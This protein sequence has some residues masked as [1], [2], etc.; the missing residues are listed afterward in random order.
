VSTAGWN[1]ACPDWELRIVAGESIIPALP[2]DH[3]RAAK[4]LRI[5]KRLKIKDVQGFPT[6]GQACPQ[7][8]FDFVY[9]VF[10]A[11]DQETKKQVVRNFLLMISKKNGKST[12]AA[13]VMMTAL[14]LND[15]AAGEFTILAPTK[16]IANN[17]FIP[18][19]GMVELDPQLSDLFK[20]NR[21]YRTIEHRILASSLRV[22]AADAETVGGGKSIATLIDEL[23]LFGK[24]SNFANILSEVEG[25]LMARPEGFIAFLTTQSD[26][27]PSGEFKRILKHMRDVRDGVVV[28]HTSLPVI[29]EF[30]KHMLVD[31]AWRYDERLWRIPNPS[32]GYGADIDFIRNGLVTKT[33]TKEAKNLFFAKHFNI[34]VGL[35]QRADAWAG[36]DYWEARADRTITLESLLERCEVVTVGGDGGGLDDML[37]LC[38]LGRERGTRKWL[39]WTRAW[40][41][42]SVLDLRK[43]EAA[44]FRD[45]EKDGDLVI[46]KRQE[47]AFLAFVD[48]VER[49]NAAGLL[50]K[51]GLDPYGVGMIV[52]ELARR[53]ITQD[54]GQ[55]EGVSQ[56]YKLQG[57]IK[58][59]E[60]Q[61]ADGNLFHAGQSLMAW[62]VGNAKIELKGNAVVVTKQASGTAKIDPVMAMF[63]AVKLMAENP[64]ISAQ[65]EIFIL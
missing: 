6:M 56:G 65:P 32:L 37:G 40:I 58:T 45:F 10:G 21:N 39:A 34:E 35:R 31:E 15:R 38:A 19:M 22:V 20:A 4:A 7:W 44:R 3:E 53:D 8:V 64:E 26:E 50:A 54:G 60:V 27:E 24:S 14:I 61:L 63:N 11:R 49:I 52:D 9:A 36:A 16:E 30:P 41:H 25:A 62:C 23:W 55:V 48:I 33:S 43:S 42:E 1:T 5:F 47:G 13:G 18:A 28:D 59:A 17:S 57:T 46:V 2:Y 51:V 29:Y 12:I